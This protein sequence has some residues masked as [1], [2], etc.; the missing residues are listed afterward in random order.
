[1]IAT[2]HCEKYRNISPDFLVWKFCGKAQFPHSFGRIARNYAET[3]TFR[4]LSTPGNQ[5]KLRYFSQR[6]ILSSFSKDEIL[7]FKTLTLKSNKM[8]KHIKT[9]CRQQTTNCLSVFD[10]FVKLA[11]EGLTINLDESF[12]MFLASFPAIIAYSSK[13]NYSRLPPEIC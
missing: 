13:R 2:F 9:I 7:F 8:V 1:M 10:H 12:V 5:V 11:L 6:L 4:H 3:M